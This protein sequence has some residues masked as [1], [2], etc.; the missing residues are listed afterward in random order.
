MS[1]PTQNNTAP[2]DTGPHAIS[3]VLSDEVVHALRAVANRSAFV[4]AALRRVLHLSPGGR[5][6]RPAGRPR[7]H[8]AEDLRDCLG[9]RELT[10]G[11]FQKRA[12][13]TLDISR[14]SFYRLLERGRREFLFRQRGIDGKWVAVPGVSKSQNGAEV[15]DGLPDPVGG[16]ADAALQ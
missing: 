6:A 16:L 7:L 4:D 10:S 12:A 13:D 5:G 3:L 9:E 2:P 15:P 14:S 11:E 1:A 8:S